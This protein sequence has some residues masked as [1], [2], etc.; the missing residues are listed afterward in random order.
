MALPAVELDDLAQVGPVAVDLEAPASDF[1]PVVEERKRQVVRAKERAEALLQAALALAARF[2]LQAFERHPHL[3][4]APA[5]RVA[6]DHV[7][8]REWI[9]QLWVTGMPSSIVTSSAGSAL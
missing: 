5:A 3:P 1:D 2:V 6:P 4:H 9:S 8:E 7:P